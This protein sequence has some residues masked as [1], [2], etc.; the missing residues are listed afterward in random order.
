MTLHVS[1][2]LSAHHQEF[3]AV[4]R[5]WYILFR[6]DDR[7][8]SGAGWNCAHHQEL[9]AVHR[10][11]YVLCRFYDRL[12]SEA[13]WNWNSSIMPLIANGHQ[14]CVKC[15]SADIRLRTPDDGHSSIL[16]LIAN[17]HQI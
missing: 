12:L 11:R 1:A 16:S 15:T 7:L 14:L 6:F 9:L 4:H 5:H 13:G 2:S 3:L 8:L 10:N 17:G